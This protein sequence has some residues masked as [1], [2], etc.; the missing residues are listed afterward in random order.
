MAAPFINGRAYDW[1][2][3]VVRMSNGSRPFFGISAIKYEDPQEMEKNFGAGNLPVSYG[4]GNINPTASITLHMEELE[5][6]AQAT[7]TGRIQDIPMFDIT[8]TFL[9]P[10]AGKV[11][12]HVLKN[13][14]LMENGRDMKQNDKKFEKELPLLLSHIEWKK[15]ATLFT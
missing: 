10:D 6:I 1:G 4:Y 15:G 8:V 9:N 14:K 3:I 5:S 7:P 11:V 2:Q 13:C 12:T